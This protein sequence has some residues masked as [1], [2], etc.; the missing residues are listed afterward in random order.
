M[1]V[2]LLEAEP[3]GVVTFVAVP[4]GAVTG[5]VDGIFTVMAGVV[6]IGVDIDDWE[7]VR[8]TTGLAR[9]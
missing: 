3:S 2:T 9:T 6:L 5:A 7:I 1:P 4:V 8:A